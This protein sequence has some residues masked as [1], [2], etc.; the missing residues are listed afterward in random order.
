MELSKKITCLLLVLILPTMALSQDSTQCT[1]PGKY[2]FADT[3]YECVD[4]VPQVAEYCKYSCKDAACTFTPPDP[5][6][7]YGIIKEEPTPAIDY[8]PHLIV[9]ILLIAIIY[10]YLRYTMIKRSARKKKSSLSRL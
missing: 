7:S 3:L 1:E 5:A 9:S 4:S 10:L 8:L 2:C 6:V